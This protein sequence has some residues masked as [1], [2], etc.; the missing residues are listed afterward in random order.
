MRKIV[1][2]V[3]II[4]G[5]LLVQP[6]L[7]GAEV[8]TQP[9]VKEKPSNLL[10]QSSVMSICATQP[11]VKEKPS[12]LLKQ[13]SVMSICVTQ[14]VVKEKPSMAPAKV[15]QPKAAE[16]KTPVKPMALKLED[17]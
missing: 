11:V 1:Y 12:N 3:L 17:C 6:P 15:Q 9:V 4:A 16:K 7:M 2:A 5:L 13:S 14:P 10:K 8:A